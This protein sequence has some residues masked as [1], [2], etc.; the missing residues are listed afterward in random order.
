MK[1]PLN[2]QFRRMQKLAGIITEGMSSTAMYE[3]DPVTIVAM[4]DN[5][6]DAI[7]GA[8]EYLNGGAGEITAD[9]WM[10]ADGKYYM[11]DLADADQI[12][13]IAGPGEVPGTQPPMLVDASELEM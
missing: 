2:E 9:Q 13:H 7:E 1:Q 4:Y 11:E 5:I 10:D 3:G 6:G 8:K 12:A